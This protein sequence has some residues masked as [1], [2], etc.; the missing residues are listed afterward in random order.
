[1]TCNIFTH[2][3]VV[4]ISQLLVQKKKKKRERDLISTR[5]CFLFFEMFGTTGGLN[6]WINNS[7]T[8]DLGQ[9]T[10]AI[11]Y[12]GSSAPYGFRSE[13][14]DHTLL[15]GGPQSSVPVKVFGHMKRSFAYKLLFSSEIGNIAGE[16]S[17]SL[18]VKDRAGQSSTSAAIW[19]RH[20]T[21]IKNEWSQILIRV[22]LK[23][24]DFR[25]PRW[26]MYWRWL[27]CRSGEGVQ[28]VAVSST[29]SYQDISDAGW[30]KGRGALTLETKKKVLWIFLRW[31]IKLST[32]CFCVW[33]LFWIIK[34]LLCWSR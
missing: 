31:D 25:S 33:K 30:V 3:P 28:R 18:R 2:F 4:V 29:L 5:I 19:H 10:P 15:S 24:R 11:L 7:S 13:W 32:A 34:C 26:L 27:R 1:M 20:S 22:M 21:P 9:D 14:W 12:L 6:W 23:G 16:R 17:S 8:S